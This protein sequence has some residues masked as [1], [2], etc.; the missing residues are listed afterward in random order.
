MHVGPWVFKAKGLLVQSR[1]P[2]VQSAHSLVSQ[3]FASDFLPIGHSKCNVGDVS[4]C[5]LRGKL[6]LQSLPCLASG[7]LLVGLFYLQFLLSQ[8]LCCQRGLLLFALLLLLRL[9]SLSGQLLLQSLFLLDSGFLHHE[10][11]QLLL[12]FPFLGLRQVHLRLGVC[13]YCPDQVLVTQH[14][15]LGRR[16]V[17]QGLVL[18]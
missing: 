17:S 6:F 14:A 11:L 7:F 18:L 8:L 1:D 16:L 13:K 9:L 3:E 4:L 12:L 10:L 15:G 5:G 2:L